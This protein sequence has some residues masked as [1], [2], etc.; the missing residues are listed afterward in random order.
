MGKRAN[1]IFFSYRH[2]SKSGKT[3]IWQVQDAASRVLGEIR[4]YASWRRY[5]LFPDT[6]TVWERDC[7]RTVAD[8]C[9]TQTTKHRRK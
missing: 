5:A 1:W 9:E 8:F 3:N 7:L 4:W 2:K 6:G